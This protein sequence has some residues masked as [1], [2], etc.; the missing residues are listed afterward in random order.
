MTL[1]LDGITK[2]V[3]GETHIDGMS[4]DLEPGSFNVL[5]GRT[6]AGKTTLLRLI[7]GLDRPSAGR[8]LDDGRDVTGLGAGRRDVAM[9][10]QQF[11]NYPSFTVFENIASPLRRQGLPQDEI[12][13]RV[14]R[15]AGMLHIEGLLDRL[16]SQLSGGQ[17]QRTAIARALVKDAGLLLLDEPLVNLDYKLREELREELR[18]LFAERRTIV[19]YATTEPAEALVLGGNTAVLH[20][21]R[22]LQ[23]GPTLQVYNRPADTAVGAIFSDPPMNFVDGILTGDGV[24]LS[25]GT[26]LPLAA[27]DRGLPSGPCRIG[28]R[29]NHLSVVRRAEHLVPIEARVE[30]AE[31]SGSETFVHVV[32]NGVPL[33]AQEDGVHAHAIA[34]TIPVYV[35]PTRVFVFAPDGRLLAAPR[36]LPSRLKGVA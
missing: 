35:D 18:E 24:A 12:S 13:R 1:R 29:A 21:G 10:Y 14:H 27:H 25:D 7:A 19:V 2:T 31:I 8:I 33:V 11:I 26:R 17:Q 36:S 23:F 6:L 20:E 16:P 3:G 4:L 30:L 22:L 15:M 9:V 32:H 28:V 34:D 5:L